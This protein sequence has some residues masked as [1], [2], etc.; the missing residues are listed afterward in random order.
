MLSNNEQNERKLRIA[1]FAGTIMFHTL[2]IGVLLLLAFHTNLPLPSE[3][4]VEVTLG[5]SGLDTDTLK[6][7][8]PQLA[9]NVEPKPDSEKTEENMS[10]DLSEGTR[11]AKTKNT[12]KSTTSK[13]RIS[14][15]ETPYKS[16]L[17]HR[18]PNSDKNIKAHSAESQK[19]SVKP[20]DPTKPIGTK[21]LPTIENNLEN[22]GSISFDLGGRSARILP[23]P[24]FNS[25][26]DGKIVVSVKVDIEGKI[27]SASAGAKGTTI[28]EPTLHKQAENAAR[29]SLFTRD[30]NAPEDQ[31]GTI[32][33]V[34]VK[35]K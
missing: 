8:E 35:Q 27:V 20:D 33:Y 16:T 34:I 13:T 26:E 12:D 5:Y 4:G 29:N 22:G 32:T 17:I 19:I 2:T 7:T 25:S 24:T 14:I 1:A 10:N 18:T 11:V 9:L 3:E 6:S 30:P 23:K 21:F 15:V 31:R 28:T